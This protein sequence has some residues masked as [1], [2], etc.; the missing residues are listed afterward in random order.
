ML[1]A[2]WICMKLSFIRDAAD[3]H[4][5]REPVQCEEDI[6]GASV[7]PMTAE[8]LNSVVAEDFTLTYPAYSTFPTSLGTISLETR[9]CVTPSRS[10]LAIAMYQWARTHHSLT[11]ALFTAQH[12]VWMSSDATIRSTVR[13]SCPQLSLSDRLKLTISQIS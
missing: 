3:R 5:H 13:R 12:N 2:I 7:P 6:L 11:L 8:C 10:S 1:T 4:Q 9:R